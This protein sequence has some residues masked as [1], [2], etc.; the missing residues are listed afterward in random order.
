M[1]FKQSEMECMVWRQKILE[2]EKF[3]ELPDGFS[4]MRMVTMTLPHIYHLLTVIQDKLKTKPL[5]EAWNQIKAML[6]QAIAMRIHQQ[7]NYGAWDRIRNEILRHPQVCTAENLRWIP[8]GQLKELY[9]NIKLQHSLVSSHMAKLKQRKFYEE[10][11]RH[12]EYVEKIIRKRLEDYKSVE[13]Y[14]QLKEDICSQTLKEPYQMA[15]RFLRR[16]K[17]PDL[18]R[19]DSHLELARKSMANKK[20]QLE[21]LMNQME[22]EME[23]THRHDMEFQNKFDCLKEDYQALQRNGVNVV[24]VQENIAAILADRAKIKK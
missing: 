1:E 13:C 5:H 18:Q 6:I 10:E 12:L 2:A 20:N 4:S 3:S 15:V 14:D 23:E 9:T 16:L 8:R 19:L 11:C 21:L 7:V 22:A 17:G 24:S